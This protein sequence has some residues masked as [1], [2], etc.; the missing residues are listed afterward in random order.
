MSLVQVDPLHPDPAVIARAAE[1]LRAGRL[2]AFPTETVYGLG[3]NA[4]DAAAVARIFEA[5]G[6]PSFNPLIV[7]ALDATRAF[8]LMRERNERAIA[9]AEAFWPG[10]LT[11]V[12]P[13]QPRVPDIV[14]AGLDSVAVR[15]PA[16]P[17]AQALLAE[18]NVPIAAPSANRSTM[19]SPTQGRHVHGSLGERVDLIL[20]AGPTPVG[21]ESTVIDVSHAMPTLL[22][23][24]TITVPEIE[25]VIG[26]IAI[27]A[28]AAATEGAAL[29][30]PGM[31]EKHY[32]PRARVVIA[33][34][35]E[36]ERVVAQERAAGRAV[37]AL[38]IAAPIVVD[39]RV[40]VMPSEARAYAA[41]LYGAL[42]EVDD[43]GCELVVV[44]RVPDA[45]EWLGVRDRVQRAAR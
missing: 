17:V 27:A 6:R 8:A 10:P 22:R 33:D 16:H 28:A 21:I 30:S 34:A 14:T 3:A 7:H 40:I 2:V 29:P 41:R 45:V 25:A 35:A 38:V 24:G 20:D 12:M 15:V 23:P 39:E 5:K 36:V 1:L 18:A 4:L 44:E 42:H 26:P 37:G 13:K 32:S 31:M 11:L 19:L 43:A 9:L